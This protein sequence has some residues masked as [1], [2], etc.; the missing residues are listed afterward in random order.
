MLS[1]AAFKMLPGLADRSILVFKSL[2]EALL[3][4]QENQENESGQ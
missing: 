1:C 2:L 3:E 4:Q